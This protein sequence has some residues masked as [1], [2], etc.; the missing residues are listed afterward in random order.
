MDKNKFKILLLTLR[1]PYPP[2][3]GGALATFELIKA[4]GIQGHEVTLFAINTPKHYSQIEKLPNEFTQFLTEIKSTYVNTNIYIIQA[5]NNLIFKRTAYNID[6]FNSHEHRQNLVKI[7]QENSFDLV[8]CEGVYL[9]YYIE[10][11]KN[12]RPNLPIILRAHNVEYQ[13]WERYAREE[14]NKLKSWY[15]TNLSKRGKNFEVEA[16]FKFDGIIA[17]TDHD[18]EQI[19]KLGF[20]GKIRTITAGI[21]LPNPSFKIDRDNNSIGFLAN[22]EW[23]P[24]IQGLDW[25]LDKV[26]PIITRKNPKIILNL[27]GKKMPTRILQLNSPNIKIHGEI[28]SPTEYLDNQAIVIVPLL[29]GSGIRM[30]II[31]SMALGKCVITT[32]AGI[33]GMKVQN[34]IHFLLADSPEDFAELI[35]STL[36]KPELIRNI[37]QNAQLFA[38]KNFS[39]DVMA[40]HLIEFFQEI[41]AEISKT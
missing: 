9:A 13:I 41:K 28:A 24:N 14:K 11:L 8:I 27:A 17:L 36:K 2:N 40:D 33:S 5:L 19:K 22:M 34:G 18:H 4:L 16:F 10:A 37:G 35:L 15:F 6:R 25:F 30:K 7:I 3:D 26:F 23:F 32:S 1:I 21:T 29:S 12:I 38:Q 31:E 39:S 20:N